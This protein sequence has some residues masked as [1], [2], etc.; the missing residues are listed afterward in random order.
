MRRVMHMKPLPALAGRVLVI[1]DVITAG[2][3]VREV[4]GLIEAAGAALAGVVIGLDRQE[5]GSGE[6]SA[7]QEVER[8]SGAPVFG[9]ITLA[10]LIEYLQA[11][12][13][14]P[15]GALVNMQDYRSRYGV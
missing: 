12:G 10:D 3:A 13:A 2:T 7:V 11:S 1:D 14:G 6:L 4:I 15:A 5:R 9:I 8:T